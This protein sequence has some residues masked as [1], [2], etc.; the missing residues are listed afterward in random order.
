MKKWEQFSKEEIEQFVKDSKSYAELARKIGYDSAAKNGSAY[1]TV[2][3][4]IDELNLDTSHFTGQGWNKDNFDYS[5]FKYGRA[6]KNG[7]ALAAIVNLR[8]HKCESCGLSEWMGKKITLEVH[9]IDG[10][11]LNN[12]LDNLQLLCPNCH[13]MTDNWKGRGIKKNGTDQ[14][15][16]VEFK[17][18]LLESGNIRQALIRLNISPKGGNYSRAK[19]IIAKYNISFQKEKSYCCD[20]GK[21]ISNRV[22]R[23]KEC[24]NKFRK[25]E[26]IRDLPVTRQQLKQLIRSTS[27]LQISKQ[28]GVS[29]N[30]IRKW[31]IKLSLQ[32]RMHDIRK[33]SDEEWEL[34]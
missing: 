1:R 10:N 30:A 32:C 22:V 21:E 25:I 29:D 28:F 31:C 23:C 11:S 7:T 26:A 8:G 27:F 2:H 9:H 3:Q 19:E 16:E 13:S 6:I 33:Y 34:I 5:R 17:N 4:M 14:I 12:E 24:E 20:C 15:S 18:V